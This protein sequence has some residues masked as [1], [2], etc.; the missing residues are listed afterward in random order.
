MYL[1]AEQ[2]LKGY[3]RRVE[4]SH[5]CDLRHVTRQ[6][7]DPECRRLALFAPAQIL[8]AREN[9]TLSADVCNPR[10][11]GPGNSLEMAPQQRVRSR[12]I[13]EIMVRGSIHP[14]SAF[15][16]VLAEQGQVMTTGA[17]RI[18]NGL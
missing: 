12:A 7:A 18:I 4:S 1:R 3:G 13:R 6:H 9:F 11:F 5:A 10:S 2:T 17:R 15:P 8:A 16:H 14:G